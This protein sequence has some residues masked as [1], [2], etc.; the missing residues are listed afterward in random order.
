MAVCRRKDVRIAMAYTTAYNTPGM[1]LSES[2]PSYRVEVRAKGE[3]TFAG[4]GLRFPDLQS[5]HDYATD[6]WSRWT[7][8]EAWRIV[9]CFDPPNCESTADGNH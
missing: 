3:T 6:L 4:N 1:V 7:A 8:V 2:A 9:D 5:A